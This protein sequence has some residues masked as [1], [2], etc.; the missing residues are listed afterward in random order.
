MRPHRRRVVQAEQRREYPG[1]QQEEESGEPEPRAEAEVTGT[2]DGAT[3]LEL[4]RGGVGQ[5]CRFRPGRLEI[6]LVWIAR[7]SASR[8][9]PRRMR[10]SIAAITTSASRLRSATSTPI[11]RTTPW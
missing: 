6:E 7:H 2:P 4:C 1:A 9:A 8:Y 11:S 10:G 3:R 5:R